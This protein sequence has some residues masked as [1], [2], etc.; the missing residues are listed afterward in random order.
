[1]NGLVG[2]KP[3]GREPINVSDKVGQGEADVTQTS[4]FV[5]L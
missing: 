5:W 1:M 3:R 2:D 4:N